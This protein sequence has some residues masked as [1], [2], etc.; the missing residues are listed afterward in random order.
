MIISLTIPDELSTRA[1][2]ALCGLNGFDTDLE[3]LTKAQFAKREIL[4]YVQSQMV[5]WESNNVRVA[6]KIATAVDT[7][8]MMDANK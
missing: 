3:G 5:L 6:Q 8:L 4:E 2:D 7:K 1:V